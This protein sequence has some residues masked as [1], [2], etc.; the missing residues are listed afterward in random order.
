MEKRQFSP[1]ILMV[2]PRKTNDNA[3]QY[4]R[5]GHMV[6]AV[7]VTVC[8]NG[9][10]L[11]VTYKIFHCADKLIVFLRCLGRDPEV[12]GGKTAEVGGVADEDVVVPCQI[13]FE[14]R[15]GIWRYLRQKKVGLCLGGFDTRYLVQALTQSF[16]FF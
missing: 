8:L 12:M 16:C 14:L 1:F 5:N 7:T 3:L 15:S 10:L 6:T 2:L 9:L 11:K 13:V 4:Y